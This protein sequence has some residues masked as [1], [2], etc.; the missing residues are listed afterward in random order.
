M[1]KIFIGIGHGGADSGAVGNGFLEKDLNLSIATF[2]KNKLEEYGIEVLMSRN[3]DENEGLVERIRECNEYN[4]DLCLDIHNN[5]GG[6]DGIEIYRSVAGGKSTELAQNI[7]NAVVNIGQNSRGVKTK[8]QNDGNDWFGFVRD[9][10]APAVLVE[11]AF[12]DTVDVEIINTSDK[13][14]IMGEAIAHG[15]LKTLNFN[16]ENT[17]V[18]TPV[19]IP[20]EVPVEVPVETPVVPETPEQITAT[21]RIFTKMWLGWIDNYNEQNCDGYAGIDNN[22]ITA[23]QAK[24]SKGQLKYRV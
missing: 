8:L 21:Y 16:F 4:P 22:N 11:C 19:E 17:P 15:I 24:L 13:Q 12:V 1:S 10:K 20:V 14:K 3:V 2:C 18:E 7:E 5:A 6:G 23:I 9:T